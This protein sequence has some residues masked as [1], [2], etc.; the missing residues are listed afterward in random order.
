MHTIPTRGLKPVRKGE[1]AVSVKLR[2]AWG[3]DVTTFKVSETNSTELEHSLVW[4]PDTTDS[5]YDRST[6]EMLVTPN[7]AGD[8]CY[9]RIDYNA[10]AVADNHIQGPIHLTNHFSIETKVEDKVSDS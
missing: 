3:V 4:T 8:V 1:S 10:R 2:D 5:W 6:S 9:V 7:R